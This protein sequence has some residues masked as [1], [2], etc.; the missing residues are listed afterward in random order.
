MRRTGAAAH[1]GR[2]ASGLIRPI[3]RPKDTVTEQMDHRD[4][5]D[6]E[7]L[8]PRTAAG[9]ADSA[10]TAPSPAAARGRVPALD[11]LRGIAILGTLASNIWIFT[12]AIGSASAE[13]TG[14]L[15][16]ISSWVPNG[17]FLGLLTI[18]FGIGLEIQ[19]QSA[20]RAGKR[21][22]G[23]YPWRA[24]LLFVDGVLNYILVVQFDVLRAYAVV[25]V[26]V[27]FLLLTSEKIQ[28][29]LI[30][31][32]LTAHFAVLTLPGLLVGNSG[33]EDAT[34]E[35]GG[36]DELKGRL[37]DG[38]N[39]RP[40]DF[41]QSWWD[42]VVFNVK[43]L[44]FGF[45][46]DSEFFTILLMGTALF[47]LGAK[48]Y[49]IGIF[50]ESRRRLRLWLIAI[51][52]GI[53][54]PLDYILGMTS[55]LLVPGLHGLSRYGTA[56]VVALGILALVAEYVDRR[57]QIGVP[58]RLMS[59]VGQMALSC[60]L[61]QNILGVIAQRMIFNQPV[62]QNVDPTLGTYAAFLLIAAILIVFSWAW[63][64]RFS[65]GP[66]EL[67]WNWTYRKLARE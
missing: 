62:F 5:D 60:Y 1:A 48:L 26:L 12:A 32:F 65:R 66:F 23:K 15:H 29:W 18:M 14:L 57:G 3:T 30:G 41:G 40:M 6:R 53:A 11:V 50:T 7:S 16:A 59:Y 27:A 45:G 47:L 44:G 39:A 49:R 58:G 25:G 52:F 33:S 28:W 46:F 4:R 56:F 42:S 61:L 63:L 31:A 67:V 20:R 54:L 21:W 34:V 36:F 13:Q 51:G 2:S 43:N 19:R 38:S 22:P 64:Q 9:I 35:A 37:P 8:P 10:P 55:V 17:K 24:L